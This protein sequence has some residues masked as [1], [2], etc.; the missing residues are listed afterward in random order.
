MASIATMK[1]GVARPK[2][3]VAESE[4]HAHGPIDNQHDESIAR[5]WPVVMMPV[6]I[7]ALVALIAFYLTLPLR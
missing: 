1:G 7:A 4:V 5:F 2:K 3:G 6:V